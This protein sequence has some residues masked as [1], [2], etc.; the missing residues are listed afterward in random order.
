MKI[1]SIKQLAY[2]PKSY[3]L[4][5]PCDIVIDACHKTRIAC[6]PLDRAPSA[7]HFLIF[8]ASTMSPG[9][10]PAIRELARAYYASLGMSLT[11]TSCGIIEV[12]I[13]Y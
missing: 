4:A 9:M 3:V 1:T 11:K 8:P 10:G 2:L 5:S 7:P 12:N 13:I 6:Y